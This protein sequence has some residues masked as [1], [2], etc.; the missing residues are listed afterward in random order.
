MLLR[1]DR[2]AARVERRGS[3]TY[4]SLLLASDAAVGSLYEPARGD[5]LVFDPVLGLVLEVEVG[6]SAASSA[7]VRDVAD[8]SWTLLGSRELAM[9]WP[10]AESFDISR[11]GT[12][13]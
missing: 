2:G 7:R 10:S 6:V 13:A 8:W 9:A 1:G 3:E 11:A 4:L 5:L 12:F